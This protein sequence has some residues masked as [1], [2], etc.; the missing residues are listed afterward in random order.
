MSETAS[1]EG[2]T[3]LASAL[4]ATLLAAALIPGHDGFCLDDAWIHLAYAASLRAGDGAS[5][6][7]GDWETGFS[8]PLWLA[9]LTVWPTGSDPVVPVKLLGA[10][11][12]GA[13]AFLAAVLALDLARARASV[14][15]P[16]PLAAVGLLAGALVAG[17]P[18]LLQ[19]AVSGME[20]PLAA[21]TILA[22]A[23]ALVRGHSGLAAA[24]AAAAVLARPEALAFVLP[25]AAALARGRTRPAVASAAGAIVALSGWVAYCAWVS[26]RPWPN[27]RYVKATG[28]DALSL[29][30]LLDEVLPWQPWLVGLGGAVLFALALV[31]ERRDRSSVL[32]ALAAAWLL[33]GLGIALSRPLHPGVLFYE[34][35][36]FAILAAVPA[37]VVALALVGT[38]RI[39]IALLLLP[40]ALVTGLQ[41]R[42]LVPLLSA[43]ERGV[44]LLHVDAARH[45]A[46]TLPADAVVAVEAAGAMRYFAPRSM[47]IVD[48]IG[49]NDG[50]IAHA[51]DD[52]RKACALARRRPTHFVLPEHIAAALAPVFAFEPLASFSDPAYAQ[53]DPPHP[54]RVVLARGTLRPPWI[55]RC[56]MEGL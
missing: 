24:A 36:Y 9:L 18:T 35:R 1:R 2:W 48:V 44:R 19:G 37:V 31:Q 41:L 47:T 12:H 49:L 22:A 4:A 30:Y 38:R 28:G 29:R 32:A 15:R 43:Q 50:E 10:L 21:A 6:N 16:V 27:A 55:E 56:G 26:G 7:P 14:T 51:P 25:L 45:V 34:G 20:V 3:A 40:V 17:T 46:Q 13:T 39:A 52:A 11:L 23:L 5:Y 53:V 42:E 8:S 33:A 54:M